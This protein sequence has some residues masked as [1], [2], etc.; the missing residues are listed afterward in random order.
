VLKGQKAYL[1]L[2]LSH[3]LLI[4]V[5]VTLQ[6][7]DLLLCC[8]EGLFGGGHGSFQLGHLHDVMVGGY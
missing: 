2:E 7:A 6:P 5:P 4:S 8:L 1:I 3:L